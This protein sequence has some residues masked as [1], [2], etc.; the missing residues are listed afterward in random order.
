VDKGF[1]II[2]P[3]EEACETFKKGTMSRLALISKMKD[4]GMKHRIII[5][6]RRSKGNDRRSVNERIVLPRIIDVIKGIQDLWRHRGEAVD[7]PE[8]QAE[9]MGCDLSDAYCHFDVASP[10]LGHCLAPHP[11]GQNVILFKPC[12]LALKQ[13]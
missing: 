13:L 4:T 3:T 1:A 7:N 10:E 6:L 8:F 2:M 5:D 11:D 12:C 9:M